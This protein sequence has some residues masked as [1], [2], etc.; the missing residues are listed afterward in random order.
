MFLLITFQLFTPILFPVTASGE[1]VKFYVV[2][3]F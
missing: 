3:M 1:L 2:E